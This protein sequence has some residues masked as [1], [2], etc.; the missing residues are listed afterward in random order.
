M[1][2]V[3]PLETQILAFITCVPQ[4]AGEVG[5]LGVIQSVH[6]GSKRAAGADVRLASFDFATNSSKLLLESATGAAHMT[7]PSE[8]TVE[9][10]MRPTSLQ[11]GGKLKSST[12]RRSAAEKRPL[13][14]CSETGGGAKNERPIERPL[15]GDAQGPASRLENVEGNEAGSSASSHHI[16]SPPR[17]GTRGKSRGNRE[18][19]RNRRSS[20]SVVEA[21]RATEGGSVNSSGNSGPTPC[22]PH[23]NQDSFR[24]VW[25][26]SIAEPGSAEEVN[27]DAANHDAA[28]EEDAGHAHFDDSAGDGH[29]R[30]EAQDLIDKEMMGA[31]KGY[32]EAAKEQFSAI[33]GTFL[34][35]EM[36]GGASNHGVVKELV[37]PRGAKTELVVTPRGA[38]TELMLT[39]RGAKTEL[40][41]LI[42]EAFSVG[43]VRFPVVTLPLPKP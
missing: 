42:S 18:N 7:D 12:P 40:V 34:P 19:N 17:I 30:G 3:Q 22:P 26:D 16:G 5:R 14:A 20:G 29:H 33:D 21:S 32:G 4:A 2:D 37:T 36:T 24:L 8:R 43:H 13:S 10:R 39:P 38:K 6:M 41:A 15:S 25:D 9:R 1:G 31:A 28:E 35:R 11:S 27:H 23:G